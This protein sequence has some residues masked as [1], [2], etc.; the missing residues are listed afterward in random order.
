MATVSAPSSLG[1]GPADDG[2]RLTLDEFV[3]AEK[4]HH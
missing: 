3:E 2:R 1:I 4:E